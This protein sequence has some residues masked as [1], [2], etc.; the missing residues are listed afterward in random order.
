MCF[1]QETHSGSKD[2]H[3]LK[4]RRWKKEFHRNGN[5][6]KARVVVILVLDKIDLKID[7]CKRQ[8]TLHN[9]QEINLIFWEVGHRGSCCDLCRRVFCLCSPPGVL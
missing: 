7:C 4:V 9:A 6:K 1:L 3:K 5:Q 8:R 2:T